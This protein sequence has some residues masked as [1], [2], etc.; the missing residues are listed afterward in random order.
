MKMSTENKIE[1]SKIGK[2]SKIW[3]YAVVYDS[4]IGDN[5]NIGSHAEIGWAKIGNNCRIGYGVFICSGVTIEDDC[6]IAPRVCFTN[7]THPSV[8]K[9]VWHD[10]SGKPF[11]PEKTLVKKGAIIG[12]NATILPGI[13]IGEG[14]LIG[15]GS[16]L[17]KDTPPYEI[18][19]G[20]PAKKI[21]EVKK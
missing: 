2:G 3:N 15:A 6:F 14:A 21:G 11:V 13:I 4:E 9:A 10:E 12:A 18:W 16:V 20:N 19:A 5:V 17:T 8:K 1:R 7:D